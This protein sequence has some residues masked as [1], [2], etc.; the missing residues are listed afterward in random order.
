MP[1]CTNTMSSS[2]GCINMSLKIR[3]F[4]KLKQLDRIE[5]LLRLNQLEKKEY[6]FPVI[7]YLIY[8]ILFVYF[9]TFSLLIIGKLYG[10]DSVTQVSRVLPSLS[11]I[12]ISTIIALFIVSLLLS[13][14]LSWKPIQKLDKTFKEKVK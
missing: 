8:G 7:S 9:I 11:Q 14:I 4:D 6:I 3:D 13:H 12:Y 5:Y 10:Y 2:G 1:K